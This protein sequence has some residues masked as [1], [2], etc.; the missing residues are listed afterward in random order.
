MVIS[1]E[2]INSDIKFFSSESLPV[3][4][5]S[6]TLQLFRKGQTI[7]YSG[8]V[9]Y[10]LFILLSGEVEL[11]SDNKKT[12]VINSNSLLGLSAFLNKKPYNVTARAI[13]DC[14]IFF[15][16]YSGFE[17]MSKKALPMSKWV[18]SFK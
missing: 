5:E 10:G 7:F 8:H 12:A 16:S 4:D 18:L 17:E 6:G 2:S 15:I 9:P 11:K 14:R 3:L 1:T 13:S